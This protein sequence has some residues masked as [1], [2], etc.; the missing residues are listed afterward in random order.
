M[1]LETMFTEQKWN[2]LKCLSEEKYSPL[3]LAEKLDTLSSED[4]EMVQN[5]LN[6]IISAMQIKGMEASPLLT[7]DEPLD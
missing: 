5:S 4:K 7:P 1:E 2:I 6:I 3:Q